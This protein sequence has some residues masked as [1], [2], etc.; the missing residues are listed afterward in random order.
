MPAIAKSNLILVVAP[1][2]A[3][4][5]ACGKKTS[6]VSEAEFQELD[7]SK[8]Q[9]VA[10]FEARLSATRKFNDWCVQNVAG[11]VSSEEKAQTRAYNC[12]AAGQALANKM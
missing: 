10:Y 2:I 7:L 3:L 5:S 6:T 12:V 11:A 9:E 1:L 8:I 4:L